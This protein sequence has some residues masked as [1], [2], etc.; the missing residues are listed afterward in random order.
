V[1]DGRYVAVQTLEDHALPSFVEVVSA[2]NGSPVARVDLP[3][4][5]EISMMGWAGDHLVWTPFDGAVYSAT[6]PGQVITG[7]TGFHPVGQGAWAVA[8]ES[9]TIRWW[10]VATGERH[11]APAGPD[12]MPC[13]G[14]WCVVSVGTTPVARLGIVG[15]DGPRGTAEL[16][17]SGSNSL[18]AWGDHF[19]VVEYGE[20]QPDAHRLLWNLRTNTYARIP[21]VDPAEAAGSDMD[22]VV[23]SVS[24]ER[25]VV[26]NLAAID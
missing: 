23:L 12:P 6:D 26:A 18:L 14:T 1:L 15:F 5:A 4:S 10:N 16:V 19:C 9:T 11:E 8:D 24:A 13:Y 20:G 17:A 21:T 25:K 2:T 7:S 22:I 3:S